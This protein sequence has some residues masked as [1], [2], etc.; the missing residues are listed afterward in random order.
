MLMTI[1]K[2]CNGNIREEEFSRAEAMLPA[3]TD[4]MK[5]DEEKGR[6]REK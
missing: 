4:Q 5:R 3:G 6:R 1:Q 2:R